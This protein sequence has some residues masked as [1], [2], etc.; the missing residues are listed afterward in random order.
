MPL[1]LEK[2]I[3]MKKLNLGCGPYTPNGWLNVDYAIG[4]KL[5][6]VPFLSK[7]GIT[8]LKWDNNILIHNLLK[9]FP[10]DDNSIDIIY[11]SHTLEHFSKTDGLKFLSECHRVL[12]QNGTI[13]IVVPDIKPIIDKYISDDISADDILEELLSLYPSEKSIFKR[14]I[15]PF[16]F[17]PHKCMYDTPSLI[18]TMTKVGFKVESKNGMESIIEDIETI[19]HLDRTID[20]VIIEGTKR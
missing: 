7:I 3:I 10:W 13:R 1:S 19:E 8:K 4:A 12:K 15:Q 16:T 5:A 11:S 14:I 20:A 17:F 2:Q 9:P 18:N 6:K